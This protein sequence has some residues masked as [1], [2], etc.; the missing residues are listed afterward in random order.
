MPEPANYIIKD[1][2]PYAYYMFYYYANLVALNAFRKY[3]F[4]R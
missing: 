1:N 2:P 3:T 4:W